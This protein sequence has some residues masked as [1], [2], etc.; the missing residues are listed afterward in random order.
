MLHR[1]P[2]LPGRGAANLWARYRSKSRRYAS[3]SPS[4]V[5]VGWGSHYLVS[6]EV[7][8]AVI[9]N[10]PVVALES[11]IYTHGFP[12]PEN[13]QLGLDLEAIVRSHGAVPATI[14]VVGGAAK[15]GLT[16]SDQ[17]ILMEAAGKSETM[18]VSRKD[19]P[20]ILGIVRGLSQH[21][22]QV[23]PLAANI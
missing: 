13:I 3:T 17:L 15:V 5:N 19:L 8:H 16:T 1:L 11:A 20:Y 7:K 22:L 18:K 2:Q 14:G 23:L 4:Y 12:Y 10:L 6:E 21:K 9:N